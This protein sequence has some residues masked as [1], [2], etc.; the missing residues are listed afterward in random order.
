MA[1]LLLRF[2]VVTTAGC[3]CSFCIAVCVSTFFF[4]FSESVCG[5]FNCFFF[6]FGPLVLPTLLTAKFVIRIVYINKVPSIISKK[7]HTLGLGFF[8]F[9]FCYI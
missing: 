2:I 6:F 1:L 3:F 7:S 8:V 5:W 9:C 4:L